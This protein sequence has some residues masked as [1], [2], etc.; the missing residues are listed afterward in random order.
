MPNQV[1]DV[2]WRN[3]LTFD[4]HQQGRTLT[5]M[6]SPHEDP[7]GKAV[8]PKQLLLTGLAGCTGLDVASILPKMRVQ[9][10]SLRVVVEA[11]LTEDHPRTYAT[12]HMVYE[13]GCNEDDRESVERA[14]ELSVTKY[15][16]VHAMLEKASDITHEVR[17]VA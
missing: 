11:T 10:S 13:V 8:S 9:F 5:M 14:V 16:G 4:A 17:I 6:S 15:C 3:D 7:D 1:V 12:M 2:V